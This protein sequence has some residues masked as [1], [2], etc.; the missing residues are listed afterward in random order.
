[1]GRIILVIKNFNMMKNKIL[2]IMVFMLAVGLMT[3][4][5]DESTAGYTFITY[6]PTLEIVGDEAVIVELGSDYEDAGWVADL[7]GEDVSDQVE[8]ES[9]VNTSVAGVYSITYTITNEDGFSVTQS[10][11]VYVADPTPSVIFTGMHTTQAGTQRYWYS[12]EAVVSFSGYEILL[13]QVDPGVFYI[14]DFMGGYYDQRAGYGSGY[15]MTGYFQV[16]DDYTITA[17]SSSVS[18]WGDSMDYLSDGSVDPET[19]QITFKIGYASL[20][21]YTIILN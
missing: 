20:M 9:T 7:N 14:S 17:L 21:E 4:C 6:Y 5:D 13:L 19:G 15:A 3:S 11:T 18:A 2:Y 1:L 10:R 8:V 16:N 12:T